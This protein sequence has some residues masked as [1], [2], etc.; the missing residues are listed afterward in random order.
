VK[1]DKAFGSDLTY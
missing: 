1:E